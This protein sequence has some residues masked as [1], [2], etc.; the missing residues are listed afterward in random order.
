MV[1]LKGIFSQHM[2]MVWSD[3]DFQSVAKFLKE[4]Y[5]VEDYHGYKSPAFVEA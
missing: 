1:I 4:E 5:N 3:S 2:K